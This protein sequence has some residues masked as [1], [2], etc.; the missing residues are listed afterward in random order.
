M[1]NNATPASQNGTG[2]WRP[3]LSA[4]DNN[5]ISVLTFD[6]DDR[7]YAAIDLLGQPPLRGMPFA[8]AAG[9]SIAIPKEAEHYFAE[10]GIPF[11]AKG[12]LNADD[13]TAEEL[14]ELRKQSIY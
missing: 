8:L 10:A 4:Y 14:N 2:P 13:L 9:D 3:F 1:S 12:L 5:E 7:I 11:E 6:T